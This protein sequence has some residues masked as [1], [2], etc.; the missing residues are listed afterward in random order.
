M[1][2]AIKIAAELI[3]ALPK[4]RLS[5]ETTEKRQGYVHPNSLSGGVESVTIKFI[6]RD[7]TVEGLKQHEDLLRSLCERII[8]KFRRRN[9]ISRYRNP[10]AT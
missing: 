6:V 10:I 8:T 4:D 9:T 3:D 5:P 7:F 1:V 2:N